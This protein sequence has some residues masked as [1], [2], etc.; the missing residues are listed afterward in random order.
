MTGTSAHRAKVLALAPL[1]PRSSPPFVLR[2]QLFTPRLFKQSH[3][4]SYRQRLLARLHYSR[5]ISFPHF[6]Q[7]SPTNTAQLRRLVRPLVDRTSYSP[8][9]AMPSTSSIVKALTLGLSLVAGVE[10]QSSSS[11][12]SSSVQSSSSASSK[13]S[14]SA[15]GE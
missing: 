10:A 2:Q 11:S 15:T 9:P 14:G 3:V 4:H 6:I 8:A 12:S 1:C 7:L 5:F 13:A